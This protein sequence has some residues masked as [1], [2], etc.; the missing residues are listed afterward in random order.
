[1]RQTASQQIIYDV[2]KVPSAAF[3]VD[4]GASTVLL[5]SNSHGLAN[6][7]LVVLTVTAEEGDA[8]PTGLLVA[9]YYY[10]VNATTNTFELSLT[11]G[12]SS[13][14]FSDDGQGTFTFW[15]KAKVLYVA[16]YEHI[17]LAMHS[18][19]GTLT[20][21][22]KGAITNEAPNFFLAQ[23]GSN[24]WDVVSIKDLEDGASVDGDTGIAFTGTDV[25]QFEVNTNGLNYLTID[26]T[27]FTS[28]KIGVFA[29]CYESK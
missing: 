12:G 23:S 26:I 9:T 11:P 17:V 28:G 6:G 15:L 3:T 21:K 7:D 14:D 2:L 25:R 19:S 22:V 27:A 10:V 18:N 24:I 1:M 8:L 16:D 29:S 13:V 5:T 20:L 4:S